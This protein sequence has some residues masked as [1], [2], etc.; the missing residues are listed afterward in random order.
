MLTNKQY[1]YE[2]IQQRRLQML[3]HSYIY[4]VLGENIVP[5]YK[6]SSWAINLAQLQE[7]HPD[8]A[9]SVCYADAFKDWDGST[10]AFLPLDDPWIENKAIYLLKQHGVSIV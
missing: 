4:Y 10:G 6:W 1:I 9:E 2:K 5:D 8:I 7:I 3:V